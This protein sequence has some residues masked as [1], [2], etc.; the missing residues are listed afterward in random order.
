VARSDVGY[1][2]SAIPQ[3]QLR[4]RYD[5]GFEDNRPD[6][7]EFFYPKCGCLALL[8]P[9]NP[10][11]DPRAPG[12]AQQPRFI[13][14]Q[15]QTSYLE[16]AYNRRLSGFVEIP[17]R[18]ID[19]DQRVDSLLNLHSNLAGLSDVNFGV[20]YALLADEE[21]YLTGQLRTFAP[22]GD[23][24]RGL[25]TDHWSLEPALLF[26]QRL[27]DRLTLEAELRDWI[28]LGGTD[29]AG[30]VLR[31]GVG[32]GCAVYDSHSLRIVPVAEV[33]GWTVL[34]GKEIDEN[35]GTV[36]DAR[37]DTI[38][39]IKTGVRTFFGA[40]SDAYVGYGRALTG[41]V[42]YKDILRVEYRLR[43]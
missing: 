13:D 34:S 15:E 27:S 31:Y 43:F 2:D 10:L 33:V 26:Y 38:V 9:T 30:N 20:K 11:F 1:I 22:T 23:A 25:G 5:A 7:A 21:R 18:F 24:D 42:W 14:F 41:E 32:L 19:F 40:H 28:P 29:F 17:V 16:V 12:P 39:N 36:F 3:T 4:F 8:P 37:G 35:V 6:R